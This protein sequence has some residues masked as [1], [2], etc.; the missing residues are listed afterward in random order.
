[1]NVAIT[2]ESSAPGLAGKDADCSE[3]CPSTSD[4]KSHGTWLRQLVAAGVPT[5]PTTI[6]SG[7]GRY[8]RDTVNSEN[9]TENS[10][11]LPSPPHKARPALSSTAHSSGGA[12]YH[13]DAFDCEISP[14]ESGAN[15]SLEQGSKRSTHEPV[16]H[17]PIGPEPTRKMRQGPPPH[18]TTTSSANSEGLLPGM[19]ATK[20]TATNGGYWAVA[21]MSSVSSEP[22]PGPKIPSHHDVPHFTASS[23][24]EPILSRPW[25]ILAEPRR[26][27]SPPGPP[28]HPAASKT[29]NDSNAVATQQPCISSHILGSEKIP[30]FAVQESST[31]TKES[32]A[33]TRTHTLDSLHPSE[34]QGKRPRRYS[35]LLFLSTDPCQVR[36]LLVQPTTAQCRNPLS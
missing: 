36:I 1:M 19:T 13:W 12:S 17:E 31:S 22:I 4:P 15:D 7:G 35:F 16:V 5:S 21:D 33:P 14:A 32:S 34:T 26:I 23:R 25:P 18:P 2:T 28:T 30:T 20:A 10:D 9:Y 29:S 6:T 27:M 11:D 8:S 24:S 3:S